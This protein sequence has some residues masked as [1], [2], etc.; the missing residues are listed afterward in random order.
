MMRQSKQNMNS[1]NLSKS[2]Q[3]LLNAAVSI[4]TIAVAVAAILTWGQAR[5]WQLGGLSIY[6]IF[7]VFGILAFSLMWAQYVASSLQTFFKAKH[8]PLKTYFEVTSIL[9]L[10]AIMLHPGLLAWQLWHD[11]F[12]LPPGSYLSHYVV[13]SLAWAALLGTVSL[14][15]FLAYEL[16]RVFRKHKWWRFMIY[17]SDAA[18]IAIFFHALALGSQ[19]QLG[20]FRDLWFFYG[21]TLVIMVAYLRICLP[22]KK[23]LRG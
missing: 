22:L 23:L 4:I 9:V 8:S 17:L 5:S 2:R 16:R 21:I 10:I 18:M 12:G 15:V 20:W 3:N 11:G 7:P 6:Q 13:P 1:V 19:L 14:L